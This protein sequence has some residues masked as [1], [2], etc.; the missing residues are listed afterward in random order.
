MTRDE[1]FSNIRVEI[2]GLFRSTP[3]HILQ[4]IIPQDAIDSYMTQCGVRKLSI[5][6]HRSDILF[7]RKTI[8]MIFYH[9]FPDT[10]LS[11]HH[12]KT[13]QSILSKAIQAQ[14]RKKHDTSSIDC[15]FSRDF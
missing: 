7:P 14:L 4:S 9:T 1:Y 12:L 5:I 13:L 10:T 8:K 15:D 3:E 2:H 6:S 11:L